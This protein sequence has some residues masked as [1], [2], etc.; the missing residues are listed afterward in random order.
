MNA[1]LELEEVSKQN[2]KKTNI[3][4]IRIVEKDII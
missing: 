1:L 3:Y 2:I 4:V